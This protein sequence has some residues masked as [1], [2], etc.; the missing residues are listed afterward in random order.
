MN[1]VDYFEKE[2]MKASLPDF[3]PGDTIRVHLRILEGEK[4]RV[5]VFEGKVGSLKRFKDDARE[6]NTGFECGIGIEGYN[7]IKIGDVIETFALEQKP[8]TLE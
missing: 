5:Q 6:V 8:A 7:D 4:E 2:Q 3:R 1:V